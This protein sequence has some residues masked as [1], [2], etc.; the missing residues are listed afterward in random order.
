MQYIFVPIV[1]FGNGLIVGSGIVALITLLDIVP[2]LCQLTKTYKYIRQ[3]EG[4]IILGSVIAAFLSLTDISIFNNRVYVV[5]IFGFFNGFFI[6]MLASAL[7]EVMNV[8]PVIVRRF[9][10]DGYVIYILYALI[11]GKVI[12][13]LVDWLII[14]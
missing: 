2:R 7:A 3:Y 9:K 10:I 12:G 11:F 5:I 6:G 14:N 8:I 13:S 1:G 4:I